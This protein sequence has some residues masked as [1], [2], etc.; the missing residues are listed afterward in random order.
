MSTIIGIFRNLGFF[1]LKIKV[2]E[3]LKNQGFRDF[4]LWQRVKDSNPHKRSQSPVCYHYTNPL[5]AKSIILNFSDLSS[6]FY[7][8][9]EKAKK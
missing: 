5:R 8:F 1:Q 3:I 7:S 9:R 6:I 2:P 4:Y